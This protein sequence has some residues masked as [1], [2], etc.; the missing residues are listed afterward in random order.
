MGGPFISQ[1]SGEE[2]SSQ[3]SATAACCSVFL[4]HPSCEVQLFCGLNCKTGQKT[5]TGHDLPGWF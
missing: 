4:V 5:S 3:A 2:G 1:G